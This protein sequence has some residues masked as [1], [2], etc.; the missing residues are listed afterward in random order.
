[1][2]SIS[3]WETLHFL[4]GTEVMFDVNSS[5]YRCSF[6]PIG[7]PDDDILYHTMVYNY[8]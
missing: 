2:D 6:Q 5:E 7:T 8:R 3:I 4:D 1:M